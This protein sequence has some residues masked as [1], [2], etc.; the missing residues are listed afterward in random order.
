MKKLL[1]LFSLFSAVAFT[2][3]DNDD[4]PPASALGEA[5]RGFIEAKYPGSVVVEVEKTYGGLLSVDVVHD[6]KKKDIYFKEGGEWLYT[7]WE[8][9]QSELPEVAADAVLA[10]YDGY[11]IDDVDYVE[12]STGDCY[13]V[14]IEKGNIEKDVYVTADG[15]LLNLN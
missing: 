4:N 1:I 14:D 2:A 6:S 10:E 5:E 12:A 8:I 7:K 3:C 11:C 13:E 15:S 9:L